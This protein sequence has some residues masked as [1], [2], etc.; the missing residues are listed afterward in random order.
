MLGLKLI[1]VSEKDT[2]NRRDTGGQD[3][4]SNGNDNAKLADPFQ[5][6]FDIPG[7]SSAVINAK[8]WSAK[9]YSKSY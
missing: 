8:M 3:I 9:K 7:I 4:P 2:V 6:R 5:L 1:N